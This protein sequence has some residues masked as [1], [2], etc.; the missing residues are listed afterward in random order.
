MKWI[1]CSEA[2]P[3][4]PEVVLAYGLYDN[5]K[6][7]DF[8]VHEVRYTKGKWIIEEED[9]YEAWEFDSVT[10]WMKMPEGPN[11]S[12]KEMETKKEWGE[13]I[14]CDKCNRPPCHYCN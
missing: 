4:D 8:G 7:D 5:S 1:K 13:T 10:H 11:E 3:N 2:M 9:C 6:P 14:K 12:S